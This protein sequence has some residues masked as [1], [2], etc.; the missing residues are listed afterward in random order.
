M[1]LSV[2]GL[3]FGR[4]GTASMKSAL[5]LLGQ[6]PTHHMGELFENDELHRKWIELAAGAEPDWEVLF[7]GY[8]AFCDWPA[9]AYWRELIQAYPEAKVVLTWRTADSWWNSFANTILEAILRRDPLHPLA[10]TLIADT[11]F[12][13]RP[14]DRAHAIGV[15][16]DYVEQVMAEVPPGRLLIHRL[17]DGWPALCSHL[18]VP[19]PDEP[20]P[21]GNSTREFREATDARR[22]APTS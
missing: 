10:L 7:N 2:I 9:A 4:T 1:P 12:G 17:G 8:S 11:V 20:Y 15:Y 16:R 13:G 3:G 21:R 14:D 19:I 18:G 5:N 6:G 22:A